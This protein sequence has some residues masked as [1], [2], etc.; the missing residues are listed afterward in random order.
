MVRLKVCYLVLKRFGLVNFNSTMVRLKEEEGDYY[1][2]HP[3]NF[4][5]T[6][7]RLKVVKSVSMGSGITNFN[8]TMVRLKV[9]KAQPVAV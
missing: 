4:N 1:A 5:S 8:S 7:V 9:L 3:S 6:M 2:T